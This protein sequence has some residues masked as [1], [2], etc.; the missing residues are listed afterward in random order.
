MS[1]PPETRLAEPADVEHVADLTLR[2]YV[3]EGLLNPDDEYVAELRD[4]AA[5]RDGAEVWV[6]VCEHRVIGSVTFCPPGSTFREL[7]GNGEGEFR[8][9]GV[10]PDVRGRGAGRALVERCLRRCRELGLR[11]IV[12][13]SMPTMTAAHRLYE[14]C[15]FVRDESLDWDVDAHLRLWGF[16]A[17][18]PV[19]EPPRAGQPSA[20]VLR[21]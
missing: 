20:G 7:A 15:G 3:G 6:A 5:R 16:R 11:E 2:A 12:L 9:L 19:T 4:V 10:D 8:R 1:S 21:E 18:V 14:S 17:V 13:C